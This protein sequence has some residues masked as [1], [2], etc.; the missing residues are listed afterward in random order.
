MNKSIIAIFT[1][2]VVFTPVVAQAGPLQNRIDRQEHRIE[3]GVRNGSISPK[4]Y[5]RLDRRIDRIESARVRDIRSG[6]K[7]NQAE[8]NRLNHRLNRTSR[9]IYRDKHN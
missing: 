8:K 3:Q 6:G 4:E 9:Q 2:L 7:L 5:R 1:G